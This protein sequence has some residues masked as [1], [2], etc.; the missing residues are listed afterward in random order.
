MSESIATYLSNFYHNKILHLCKDFTN[1]CHCQL[2][3]HIRKKRQG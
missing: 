1:F 2:D 3:F